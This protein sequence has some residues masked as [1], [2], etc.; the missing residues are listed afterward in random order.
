[1]KT[2]QVQRGPFLITPLRMGVKF[3][4]VCSCGGRTVRRNVVVKNG[5]DFDGF[6]DGTESRKVQFVCIRC[7]RVVKEEPVEREGLVAS[8]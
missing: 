2:W 7:G 5:V 4:V 6:W 1:M 3:Q 8:G